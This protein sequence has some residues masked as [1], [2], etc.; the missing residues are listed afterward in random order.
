M[1]CSGDCGPIV[2]TLLTGAPGVQ[3]EQG[4]QGVQGPAGPQGPQ[5]PAGS[6]GTVTGDITVTTEGVASLATVGVAAITGSAAQAL[7]LQTD[8]KGRVLAVTAQAISVTTSQVQ[9]LSLATLGGVA[10]TDPRLSD[11]RAPSGA[12]GGDLAGR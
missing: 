3:G 2:V 11:S 9:N 8:A 10:T 12:A 5:G 7:T 1:S 4:V 6:I